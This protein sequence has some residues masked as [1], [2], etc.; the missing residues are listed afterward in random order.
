MAPMQPDSRLPAASNGSASPPGAYS[1][2]PLAWAPSPHTKPRAQLLA[3]L[4]EENDWKNGMVMWILPESVR[5]RMPRVVKAWFRCYVMAMGLYLG[6]GAAWSYYIYYAFGKQLFADGNKPT[7]PAMLE[8]I[9]VSSLAMPIYSA[10]PAF[11][12]WVMEQGWTRVFSRV[13][14]VGVGAYL[15]YFVLYMTSVEFGVYWMHR[16]LHDIRPGYTYL[17]YIHHIYNKEHT[18]S[19]FAGLA[20]HPID[21]ILQAIPYFWTLF[22]VPAH[23]LTVELLLFGTAIWTNNIHDNLNGR[24]EPIMGAGYH[25]I[26]HTKY[27]KN[28]G[29]Y[30]VYMD[31]IFGSLLSPDK[32]A[33]Q[34]KAQ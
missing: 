21:G 30:F 4:V 27:N 11:V 14:D 6:L 31:T 2:V 9:K 19:P 32:L 12:E 8:Q 24:M 15:G 10:L 33:A 29:H 22:L 23:A 25:T 17:H 1:A 7:V 3:E 34:K 16:L 28:Y 13:S 26:H 18:M 5:Q 20:F